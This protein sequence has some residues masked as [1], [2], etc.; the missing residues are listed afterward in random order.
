MKE[1]LGHNLKHFFNN[2]NKGICTY[3]GD[4]YEVW[5]IS[6]VLF[7]YMCDM[8]EEKFVEL[9]GEEA[10]WRNAVGSNQGVPNKKFIINGE[11]IIAWDGC[12]R[13]E[14]YNDYCTVCEDKKSKMCKS[15][16]EDIDS[17]FGKREYQTLSDY[18]CDE[19]GASQPRNICALT[20]D[21]ANYNN[22]TLGELFTKYEG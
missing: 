12:N 17:C 2:I 7:K 10:W 20:I 8:S 1:I 16:D 9:A 22:V 3:E 4:R 13:T 5:E 19:I 11:E 15:L 6:N 18:L 14:F 21:L